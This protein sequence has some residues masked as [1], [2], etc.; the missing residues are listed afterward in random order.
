VDDRVEAA[1]R[2][3]L[4]GDVAHRIQA[5]EVAGHNRFG[6]RQCGARIVGAGFI[7]CVQHDA[8]PLLE[9]KARGHQPQSVRRSGDED[10]RLVDSSNKEAPI[11]RACC[12]PRDAM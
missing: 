5:R 3:R 11:L 1:K 6:S 10:A 7:A 4:L 9:Q 8:M 2:V 12:P